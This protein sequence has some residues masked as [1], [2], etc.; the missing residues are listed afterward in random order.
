M[1]REMRMRNR[2]KMRMNKEMMRMAMRTKMEMAQERRMKIK[3]K[4]E[5]E[6]AV[7]KKVKSQNRNYPSLGP[8]NQ[9][10]SKFQMCFPKLR[11]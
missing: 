8:L 2:T 6:E 11:V 5:V 9:T 3:K 7:M 4:R 1:R 10:S